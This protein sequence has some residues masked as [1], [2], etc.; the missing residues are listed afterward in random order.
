[1]NNVKTPSFQ[2]SPAT[3]EGNITIK[4]AETA[5]VP[6]AAP[7]DPEQE[8]VGLAGG[9]DGTQFKAFINRFFTQGLSSF[10]DII[11]CMVV[12]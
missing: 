8:A 6:A 10:G 2:K 5:L 4:A 3:G 9:P 1:M 12:L 11:I 7:V